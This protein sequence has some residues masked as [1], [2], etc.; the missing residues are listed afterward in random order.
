M[1]AMQIDE[2]ES[3]QAELTTSKASIQSLEEQLQNQKDQGLERD[4]LDD[5]QG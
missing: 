1:F 4:S 3:R 2:L 5:S